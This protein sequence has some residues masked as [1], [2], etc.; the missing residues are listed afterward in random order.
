MP[1]KNL[2][3]PRPAPWRTK[4]AALP[5]SCTQRARTH[6]CTER[7]S[8]ERVAFGRIWFEC[9]IHL[10][11]DGP[12]Q[13]E[14][15][16]SNAFLHKNTRNPH[17][18]TTS[19]TVNARDRIRRS[20]RSFGRAATWWPADHTHRAMSGVDKVRV[21]EGEKWSRME[22]VNGDNECRRLGREQKW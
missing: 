21:W 8:L 4:I 5:S 9:E 3:K 11:I 10:S 7:A 2:Q 16:K 14:E 13:D 19:L 20:C 15:E 17:R 1:V 12:M 6:W 18:P 22:K